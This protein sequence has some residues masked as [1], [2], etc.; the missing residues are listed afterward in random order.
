MI[1]SPGGHPPHDGFVADE[2]SRLDLS[3]RP[4]SR[5]FKRSFIFGVEDYRPLGELSVGL[6]HG[7]MTTMVG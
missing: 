5:G 3:H 2:F 7:G 6:I 1:R 4:L